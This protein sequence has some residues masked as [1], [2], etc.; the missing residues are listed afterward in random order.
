MEC[1]EHN[2]ICEWVTER[3]L[4]VDDAGSVQLPELPS[5]AHGVYAHGSRS[6]L[7]QA[8][9]Q[10]LIRHLG[11]WAECVVWIREWGIWGSGEDWPKFYAWRGAREERRSLEKAPGHR[12]EARELPVLGELLGLVMEN[13]W[14]ADIL[15]AAN[16][17]ANVRGHISHDEWFEVFGAPI[18]SP[19]A[20]Q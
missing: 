3:G 13:A 18:S 4:I 6:G 15:C 17:K 5:R 7:E 8:S 16:G 10:E 19:E 1:L 20:A 11:Q 9:A 12:F 14:D 2:Q